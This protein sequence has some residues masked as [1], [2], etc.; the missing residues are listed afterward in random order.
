MTLI[1]LHSI[2]T[3][4][5]RTPFYKFGAN[6]NRKIFASLTRFVA[7]CYQFDSGNF[8]LAQAKR[9]SKKDSA[10]EVISLYHIQNC[11]ISYCGCY[12]TLLQVIY[13][14]FE[15]GLPLKDK[16]AYLY[17]LRKARWNSDS[18]QQEKGLKQLLNELS[19]N[20][21]LTNFIKTIDSFMGKPRN[22]VASLANNLKH[23]GGL[24]T[25]SSA[26]FISDI[27]FVN[28]GVRIVK[29][30]NGRFIKFETSDALSSFKS[31]WLYPH[32]IK[33]PDIINQMVQQNKKIYEMAEYVYLSLAYDK[34]SELNHFLSDTYSNPLV[35]YGTEQTK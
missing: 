13:F 27:G 23:G 31:D 22:R 16:D 14:A 9:L 11:I 35:N 33:L 19:G 18:S 34:L 26:T 2:L 20:N 17:S 28:E 29:D 7:L 5:V 4:I 30:K 1:N 6:G 10:S 8:S 3:Q 21:Q 15:L 12:D 24:I 32:I 25:D